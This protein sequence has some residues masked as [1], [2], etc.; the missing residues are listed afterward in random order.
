MPSPVSSEKRQRKDA[1]DVEQSQIEVTS[2]A[3]ERPKLEEGATRTANAIGPEPCIMSGTPITS[4]PQSPVPPKVIPWEDRAY[5]STACLLALRRRDQSQPQPLCPNYADH[6]SAGSAVTEASHLRRHLKDQLLEGDCDYR[7]ERFLPGSG[8]AQPVKIWL[9]SHGY[10]I[11]AKVFQPEE[12][13]TLRH[14]AKIYDRLRELQGTDVPVCLGT[15][16]LPIES[17]LEYREVHSTGLLL[18]SYAG[19]GMNVW[20]RLGLGLGTGEEADRSFAHAQTLTADV[21]KA[22]GRIHDKGVLHRDVA[23]RNVLVQKFTRTGP[24]S[25]SKFSLQIQL[26]DFERSRTRSA[27][28][29]N[30]AQVRKLRGAQEGDAGRRVEDIGNDD[31]GKA[32]VKEM[33]YCSR[34]ISEW[35]QP[36]V[37]QDGLFHPRS[38][39]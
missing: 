32:C 19:F 17:S 18:L 2:S 24:S 1:E 38:L 29:Y 10:I 28:R 3:A 25:H 20:P 15:L 23:L 16:E 27:Y 7:F 6:K 14:E 34:V 21:M 13:S 33:A 11:F 8:S 39:P 4:P 37:I 26:I 12:I 30:A 31:F 5:C 36:G 35:Y 22:L 9:K